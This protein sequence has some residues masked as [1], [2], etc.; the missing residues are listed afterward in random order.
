MIKHSFSPIHKSAP[1]KTI[2]RSTTTSRQTKKPLFQKILHKLY[3]N[4]IEYLTIPIVASFVGISTNYMG[5]QMLFY[6]L[7][8][9]PLIHI[10]NELETLRVDLVTFEENLSENDQI[11]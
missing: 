2:I 4:L 3:Q 5:V 11:L 10:K 7:E 9:T 6:P 1:L 8:Y